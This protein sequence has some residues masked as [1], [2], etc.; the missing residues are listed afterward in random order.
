MHADTPDAF[1]FEAVMAKNARHC[2]N[3]VWETKEQW[4]QDLIDT[5]WSQVMWHEFGHSLGL[6]HNFMA[7]VDGNNFPHYKDGAG[8]DHIGLYASSVM[9]YNAAPDRV[10]S[11]PGWA[12]HDTDAIGWLYGSNGPSPGYSCNGPNDKAACPTDATCSVN[13]G[14]TCASS[15]D[16]A[17]TAYPTCNTSL[18]LCVGSYS[19]A[20][21]GISISGQIDAKTPWVDTFGFGAWSW[22]NTKL[23][24]AQTGGMVE[25]QYLYCNDFQTKYTPLCRQGDLGRTPSEIIANE[26][27]N[28]EWTYQ[29]RNFRLYR[30]IWDNSAYANGPAGVVTDMRRFLSMWA[31]DWSTSE[32]ADSL[33]RIGITNPD[34][35][36][37]QPGV[38]HVAHQ[39][40]QRRHLLGQPDDRRLPQGHHPDVRRRA[41]LQDDL[42]SLLR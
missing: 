24:W 11:H 10:F 12:P 33:R 32:L 9:E 30:K 3:G 7:S 29:W 40:V 23:Q 19:G 5:Y 35:N 41:P 16:C 31:F 1:S 13:T 42:R 17:G 21:S 27:D 38:L 20:C 2:I 37:Q 8:N 28:Y 25:T 36:T 34:P 6:E 18:K 4:V 39:Q 14:V 26:I 15:T 22:D